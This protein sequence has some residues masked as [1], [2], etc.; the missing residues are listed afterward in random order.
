M[1]G[2]AMLKIGESGWIEKNSLSAVTLDAICRLSGYHLFFRCS[3]PM[4]RS[5]WRTAQHDL[6]P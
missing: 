2:Y 4:V 3:H 5:H 6:G 1:K